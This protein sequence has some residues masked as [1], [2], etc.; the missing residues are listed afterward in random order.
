MSRSIF[1]WIP[2]AYAAFIGASAGLAVCLAVAALPVVQSHRR[3]DP[4]L[5]ALAT[6]ALATFMGSSRSFRLI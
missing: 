6:L 4:V 2:L 1:R 5:M 3:T